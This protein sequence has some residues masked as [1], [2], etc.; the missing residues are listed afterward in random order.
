MKLT[1]LTIATAL[2]LST[3]LLTQQSSALANQESLTPEQAN[4]LSHD[5][6]PSTPSQD[7][8]QQGQQKTEREIERLLQR[9]NADSNEP[10]L[11]MNVDTQQEINRLPQIQ[12]SNVLQ[13]PQPK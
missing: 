4:R 10:L 1:H 8:F 5:L 6:I 12:P 13:Q 3:G 11:R 2:L 9:Q 7:F